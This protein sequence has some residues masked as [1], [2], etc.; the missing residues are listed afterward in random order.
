MTKTGRRFSPETEDDGGPG[1]GTDG[2]DVG[3]DPRMNGGDG[4]DRGAVAETMEVGTIS[5][6]S[7]NVGDARPEKTPTPTS[8]VRALSG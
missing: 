1:S 3:V 6:L 5:Y 4:D 2:A 7:P 8:S